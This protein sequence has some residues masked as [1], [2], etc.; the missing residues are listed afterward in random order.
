VSPFE[1][2]VDNVNR[3]K[4]MT[5]EQAEE[6][7]IDT[8]EKRHNLIHAFLDKKPKN[9]DYLF[10][11]TINR[12]SFTIPEISEMILSLYEKKVLQKIEARKR[13]IMII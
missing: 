7:V 2:R 8:D 1:W 3:K 11:A 9:I 12:S 5:L 4:E 13:G 6:Y 10:D